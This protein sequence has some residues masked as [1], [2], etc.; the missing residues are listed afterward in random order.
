MQNKFF[1][2]IKRSV[3]PGDW[4]G[5]GD[6]LQ[7]GM[8]AHLK[9]ENGMLCLERTGP[10]MPPV[11]FPG[12]GDVLLTTDAR[13]LFEAGGFERMSFLPVVK[14]LIVELHWEEW[15]L[16]EP[17]P[18]EFPPGGEPE[19]YVL[20]HPHDER[21]ADALGDIWELVVPKVDACVG[22]DLDKKWGWPTRFHVEEA[23]W[24]GSDLFRSKGAG[25][26]FLTERA[27]ETFSA[28]WNDCI[29]LEECP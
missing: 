29:S 3:I 6:I 4:G 7:H 25:Q 14:K 10:Y 11:T 27:K 28:N 18:A 15:N 8:T 5:Y 22:V 24:D 17:E 26:I 13:V 16:L 12:L 2:L 1:R 9:R 20:D 23:L 21:I 19:N